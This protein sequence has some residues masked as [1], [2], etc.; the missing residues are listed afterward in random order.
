MDAGVAGVVGAAIGTLGAVAGG[1][2]SVL[3]QGRQQQRQLLRVGSVRRVH[4]EHEAAVGGVVAVFRPG[5]GKAVHTGAVAGILRRGARGVG[6]V[7]HRSR[8]HRRRRTGVRRGGGP[9]NCVWPCTAGRRPGWT[10]L[11][12]PC[13]RGTATSLSARNASNRRGRRNALRTAPSSR[14]RGGPWEQSS[15]SKIAPVT[16][17]RPAGQFVIRRRPLAWVLPHGTLS[18]IV[19]QAEALTGPVPAIRDRQYPGAPILRGPGPVASTAT[20]TAALPLDLTS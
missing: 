11:R 15:H 13:G 10:G 14:P 1:W 19:H 6:P 17:D 4:R 5:L 9:R 20:V 7:Q 8:G 18:G 2:V 3:G 12:R 16:G